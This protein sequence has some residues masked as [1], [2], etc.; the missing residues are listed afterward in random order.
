MLL[1]A[2]HILPAFLMLSVPFVPAEQAHVCVVL[3]VLTFA[4]NG[5]VTQT[6]VANYHD[7]GAATAASTKA[8][9]TAMSGTS[10]F[11]SPLVVAYFTSERV[12]VSQ[13]KLHKRC[14]RTHFE[15]LRIL[16]HCCRM[17]ICICDGSVRVFVYRVVFRDIWQCARS[18]LEQGSEIETS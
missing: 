15:M 16:E 11:L 4:L 9:V 3:M 6:T 10:G 17:E 14:N 1:L 8:I 18:E 5:A 7:L 2:A 13:W 12:S